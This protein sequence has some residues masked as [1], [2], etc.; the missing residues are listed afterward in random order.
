MKR[1][2]KGHGWSKSKRAALFRER[3]RE[4]AGKKQKSRRFMETYYST[5]KPPTDEQR[6]E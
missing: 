5:L 2:G 6:H 4:E 3:Q 1:R